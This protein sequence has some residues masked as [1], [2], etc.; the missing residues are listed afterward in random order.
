MEAEL[1][2]EMTRREERRKNIVVHGLLENTEAEGRRRL[3]ADRRQLD[4]IFIALDVN[5]SEASDVEFC[6]R[7]GEQSERPRPLIVGFFTEW[8]KDIVLKNAKRLMESELSG[9]TLVP[10]LTDKQRKAEK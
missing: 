7:V 5:V 6:R 1:R 10:D 9:V 3:E 2:E 8:A 4:E